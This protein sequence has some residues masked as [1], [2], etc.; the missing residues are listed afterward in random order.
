MISHHLEFFN[1]MQESVFNIKKRKYD[2]D[3]K[4][5]YNYQSYF[6]DELVAS[7]RKS[8]MYFINARKKEKT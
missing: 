3:V 1:R 6:P 2:F 5:L 8:N 4:K 7:S